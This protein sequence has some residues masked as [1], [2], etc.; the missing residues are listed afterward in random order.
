MGKDKNEWLKSDIKEI[1]EDIH[2]LNDDNI[3]VCKIC[4]KP[5]GS[6]EVPAMKSQLEQHLK[7]DKRIK[8]ANLKNQQRQEPIRFIYSSNQGLNQ[9]YFD[10][11]KIM[12]GCDIPLNKLENSKMEFLKKYTKY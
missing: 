1:G 9:Y 2:Y 6:R 11:T 8:N 4:T 10:L 7:T 5:L 12:V 3:V